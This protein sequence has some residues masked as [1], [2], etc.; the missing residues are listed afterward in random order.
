MTRSY[1]DWSVVSN[2]DVVQGMESN[3]QS[4]NRKAT[5]TPVNIPLKGKLGRIIFRGSTNPTAD[6]MALAL[7]LE[8]ATPRVMI[9][10]DATWAPHVSSKSLDT[11]SR[12]SEP[13]VRVAVMYGSA[14]RSDS[15]TYTEFN[16]R[17]GR[18]TE[19]RSPD[20]AALAEARRRQDQAKKEQAREIIEQSSWGRPC[21][22]L[23]FELGEQQSSKLIALI[24]SNH[25]ANTELTYALEAA[26]QFHST[27]LVRSLLT[28]FLT[29]EKP[30]VRE[31]A[32][33]GLGQHRGVPEIREI[34]QKQHAQETSPGVREAIEDVLE[35]D[36]DD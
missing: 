32:V 18:V 26:G 12:L 8:Q 23:Y 22:A 20:L 24:H 19:K 10:K 25:L 31:G 33:Y 4:S 14:M 13:K 6:A 35:G 28:P 17:V 9:A 16:I 5:G 2:R 7:R 1:H 3:R 11:R 15:G 36:S 21:K 30:Y 34:L 29:H 27:K